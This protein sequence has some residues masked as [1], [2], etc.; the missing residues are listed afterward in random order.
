MNSSIDPIFE[1]AKIAVPSALVV[2]GWLVLYRNAKALEKRKEIKALVD[3][4]VDL[5]SQIAVDGKLYFSPQ[6]NEHNGHLSQGLKT[7]L[8]LLSHY[9]FLI[10]SC[11]V[12]FYGTKDLVQFRKVLTGSFFETTDYLKQTSIPGWAAELAAAEAKL[13]LSINRSYFAWSGALKRKYRPKK[14]AGWF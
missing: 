3:I 1:I 4:T 9:L 12:A 2:V 11:N 13:K 14:K 7:N 10:E 5:V 8:T 6:N